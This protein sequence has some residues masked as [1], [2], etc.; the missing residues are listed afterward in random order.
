[1]YPKL[2]LIYS[3]SSII[4]TFYGADT[5]IAELITWYDTVIAAVFGIC[6]YL[7]IKYF[8]V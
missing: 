1:M 2:L 8:Q 6:F 7:G 3:I 4:V 5:Y